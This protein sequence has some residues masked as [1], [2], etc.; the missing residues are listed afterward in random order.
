[1]TTPT[2]TTN[3]G[4]DVSVLRSLR[5]LMPQRILSY[6]DALQR[7]EAQANRLLALHQIQSAPVPIEI[8][9]ELPHVRIEKS[10]DLPVSG[11]A[12]WD[13][14]CWVITLN[15]AEYNLRQ[16]FSVLHEYKHI[17]DHPTRH[18]ICGDKKMSAEQMAEKVADYFAACV[19]M[20]KAWVKAAF[21]GRTQSVEQLARLFHVSAKAMS[22]RLQQLGLVEPTRRQPTSA[23]V[24][25]G[26]SSRPHY[27][28]AQSVS[29]EL[30]CSL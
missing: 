25:S 15:A 5:S 13:G 20:P 17:I 26:R 24:G 27:F 6:P 8:V 7:A 3:R 9:T 14:S 4:G 23:V 28:R 30:V 1:M 10:Y 12:L 18:L 21:F 19:L 11:S 29:R 22:F 2:R 16:R